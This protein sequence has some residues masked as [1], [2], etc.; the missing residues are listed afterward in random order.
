M[1]TKRQLKKRLEAERDRLR[2]LL[3]ETMEQTLA[4]SRG[5]PLEEHSGYSQEEADAGTQTFE[6]ELAVGLEIHRRALLRE[7][8]DALE[9]MEESTYGICEDCNEK[10]DPARLEALPWART[11][12]R[13]RAKRPGE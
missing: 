12:I 11:C 8:E 9:R 7:V 3:N 4:G 10:I 2:G 1:A 5:G 13:C 6:Q